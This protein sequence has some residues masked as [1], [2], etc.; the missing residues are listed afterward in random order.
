[1]IIRTL[2]DVALTTTEE[3]ITLTNEKWYIEH[4]LISKVGQDAGHITLKFNDNEHFS[5]Y[6]IEEGKYV[7]TV[8][9]PYVLDEG[10]TFKYS[11]DADLK[12]RVV[13][14]GASEATI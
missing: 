13:L 11:A 7:F 6:D 1:M 3:T 9:F 2:A 4:L 12:F 8:P 14:V 10:Q 5:E